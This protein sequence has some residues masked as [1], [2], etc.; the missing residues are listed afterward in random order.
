V[1]EELSA[2]LGASGDAERVHHFLRYFRTGPGQ[3]GHGD[4]FLGLTVPALR[5]IVVPYR[6]RVTLAD[7]D[8]L[9]GSPYHEIRFAAL[10][11]LVHFAERMEKRND[12][13]GL[14]ELVAFYDGRLERANGWDLVDVSAPKIMG[15]HWRCREGGAAERKK[16]LKTWADSGNLWRQRAAIVS[17][18]SLVRRG[19]LEETFWLAE[20]FLSHP[21][22]LMHKAV[23]WLLREAGKRDGEA[24]RNF[25]AAHGGRMARTALRYAIERMGAEERKEWLGSTARARSSSSAG[26]FA[27]SADLGRR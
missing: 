10:L 20:Y 16:L 7:C 9:L 23:G 17:T 19:R 4:Q 22:D 8:R 2:S 5:S 1:V 27:L 13:A 14:E 11:F 24:L 21:H 12:R 18:L 26:D 3:Y 25:L 15:A 6:E